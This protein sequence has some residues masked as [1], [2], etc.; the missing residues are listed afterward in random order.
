M[1]AF[2]YEANQESVYNL[3]PAPEVVQERPPIYRSK[4]NA[5]VPPSYST[6]GVAGTSKPVANCDGGD[7]VHDVSGGKHRARHGAASIGKTVQESIDPRKFLR[8]GQNGGGSSLETGVLPEPTKFV[9]PAEPRRPAVPRQAEKPVMGLTTEK[10]F[11]VSNAVEAILAAPKKPPPTQPRPTQKSTMGR[12][13]RY[14]KKVKTDIA[15]GKEKAATLASEAAKDPFGGKMHLMS[16]GEARELV[17]GLKARWDLLNKQYQALTF[18]MDTVTKVTRK[19][20]QE[21]ELQ[22]LEKA[23]AKLQGKRCIYVYDDVG[24]GFQG[25]GLGGQQLSATA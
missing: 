4:H 15:A 22:R 3:I 23:I 12:E 13:P 11:V 8:R 10:N 16:D 7:I 5:K 14:L 2:D 25:C 9:R 19:E 20:T 24:D 1:A 6:F 21:A 18:S 17:G